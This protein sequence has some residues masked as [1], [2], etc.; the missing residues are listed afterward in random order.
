MIVCDF[1]WKSI[2][3]SD[4]WFDFGSVGC[5]S[6][7]KLHKKRTANDLEAIITL[8]TGFLE[9]F[10]FLNYISESSDQLEIVAHMVNLLDLRH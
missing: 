6:Q 8:K 7:S 3:L 1:L 4:Q 9:V 2:V 5:F 10:R